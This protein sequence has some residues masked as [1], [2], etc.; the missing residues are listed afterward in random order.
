LQHL[1][2]S[3]FYARL[4]RT[5]GATVEGLLRLDPV[6]DDPA[7]TVCAN[8]GQLMDRAFKAIKDVPVSSRNNFKV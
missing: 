3:A 5:M 1:I 4:S 2:G 8:R 6:T 7:A